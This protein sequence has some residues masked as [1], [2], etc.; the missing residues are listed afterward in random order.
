MMMNR[1][2]QKALDTIIF[3]V[4]I[5]GILGIIIAVFLLSN[6]ATLRLLVCVCAVILALCLFFTR[7]IAR[8]H[9]VIFT[10]IVCKQLDRMIENNIDEYIDLEEETLISKIGAKLL[11]IKEITRGAAEQSEQLKK[12]V[13]E[14]VSDITHQLKTPLSNIKMAADT[15]EDE[16]TSEE[17]RQFFIFGLKNQVAKLEF[18]IEAMTKISRLEN[19]VI[20]PK[21]EISPLSELLEAVTTAIRPV[22]DGKHLEI[23]YDTTELSLYFDM[24]WTTE[25]VL[26]ILDNAV[27]YTPNYG[28]IT[29]SVNQL[30]LYTRIDIND[31][32]IG[33]LPEHTNDIFKRFYREN[34]MRQADGIG[35]GL[36]LAREIIS[37]QGG[38]LTV[39]SIVDKGTTVSVYLQNSGDKTDNNLKIL[40]M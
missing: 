39:K 27:K 3:V 10:D 18:L 9:F 37:R 24:R 5:V 40:K 17:R 20:V 29:I 34:R 31:T 7:S 19:G 35:V 12:N 26:N 2:V 36:Y 8:T 14:L 1:T 21:P 32:G 30:A 4:G 23:E 33:I 38:Y 11:K 16:K 25:A 22:A 13:Q 6:S 28:K 15:L